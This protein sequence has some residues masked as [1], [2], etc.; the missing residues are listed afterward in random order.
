MHDIHK[1]VVE[2]EL[3]GLPALK[4]ACK[5]ALVTGVGLVIKELIEGGVTNRYGE[6][7][8]CC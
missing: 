6:A 5:L 1:C 2:F 3:K 4:T 7:C 8:L